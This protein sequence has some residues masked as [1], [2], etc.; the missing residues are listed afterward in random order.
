MAA[1]P[2][3][4]MLTLDYNPMEEP[5]WMPPAQR[6]H[7]VASALLAIREQ[8]IAEEEGGG[9]LDPPACPPPDSPGRLEGDAISMAV[10][11]HHSG[12]GAGSSSAGV[13]A[14]QQLSQSQTRDQAPLDAKAPHQRGPAAI[15]DTAGVTDQ[16]QQG[17]ATGAAGAV[18]AS[19]DVRKPGAGGDD[20]DPARQSKMQRW[21]DE[22]FAELE[23]KRQEHR[24]AR[25]SIGMGQC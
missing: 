6:N 8:A 3:M 18:A 10:A 14:Q 9:A 23:N 25:S 13:V 7:P 11:A 20:C 22:L 16:P 24:Q 17:V 4:S 21:R 2:R 15:S 5:S 1:G 12:G 19:V